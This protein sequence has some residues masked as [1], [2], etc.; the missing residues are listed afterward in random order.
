MLDLVLQSVASVLEPKT[1]LAMTTGILAG[2]IGGAIPGI[3]LTMTVILVLPFTFG[4]DPLQGIAT[5]I[6]VY[7]GGESGGLISA[8]LLG[9][10]GTPSAI[11]TTFDGYPMAKKGEPGR[12][13]WTGIWASLLGGLLAGIPLVIG[14]TQLAK[15]AL[16]FGPWEYFSLF[17]LTLSIVGALTEGSIIKGLLSG[18]LGLLVTTIGA[19][20][21]MS[22]PRFTFGYAFLQTGFAFLPILIGLFAFSQLMQDLA[23]RG[24]EPEIENVARLKLSVSHLAVLKDIL[25]QPFNLLWS[26]LVGL[27]I[28][29]LPAVGGSAANI[30]AYDQAKKFSKHPEKFG[31]GVSEGIVATE[32][33]NNANVGGSLI[34]MMAFGIPGDAVTA[35]MLGALIIHGIQ[36]GP[37][38]VTTNVKVAYGM[39]AAYF[40][41][42]FVTVAVEAACLRYFIRVVT[43]PLRTLVPIVLVFCV[44]GSYALN[45]I[46]ENVYAFLIFGIL[47][48][49][50]V[51]TGFPLAPMVLGVIL[52]DQIEVNLIRALMTDPDPWLFLTRPISGALLVLALLS[53]VVALYQERRFVRRRAAS[54]A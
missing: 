52:G 1:F 48:Y 33:S 10:P 32:A 15:L 53:F 46:M 6:G 14:A 17:V 2:L 38:F 7:V 35:V 41:A 27:W 39:L 30:L 21:L 4:M 24:S 34:T 47:G 54:A 51:M 42:H 23:K 36:P 13:V 40:V 8:V 3:T 9:I 50:M 37:L 43:V 28:G 11:A 45:N 44:I 29:I 16:T 25:S 49:L 26:T 5:M 20:P 18:A 19:D 12:A 31:T 22:I